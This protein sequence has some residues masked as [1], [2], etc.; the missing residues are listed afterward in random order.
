MVL[1]VKAGLVL[2]VRVQRVVAS[3]ACVR[4]AV[5]DV[6]ERFASGENERARHV[7]AKKMDG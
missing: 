2:M 5:N 4:A 7:W 6:Y 3:D 1:L